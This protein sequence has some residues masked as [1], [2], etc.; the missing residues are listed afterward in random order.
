MKKLVIIQNSI[1]TTC[2]FRA[3]YIRKFLEQEGKVVIIAPNDCPTSYDKLIAMGCDIPNILT[4]TNLVRKI[5]AVLVMNFHI[6]QQRF[7]GENKLFVCHFLVT[8]LS[9][10]FSLIPFNK[11]VFL[12]IEGLGSLYK[13]NSLLSRLIIKMINRKNVVRI[14]CNSN[15]RELVGQPD[16]WVAGGIG[17]DI[18][19]FLPQAKRVEESPS[20]FTLLYVGRL[21]GDK[22]A[23]DAI[24]V[25]KTLCQHR[26]DV[27]LVMVG[28]IY[29]NNPSSF[30]NDDIS[31]LKKEFG[32]RLTFAGYVND[33]RAWYD[34]A[35]VL[36]L[37]SRREGFPVCVMEASAMGVPSI[38]FKVPGCEDAI[39]DNENG[40]LAPFGDIQAMAALTEHALVPDNLV[41]LRRSSR[42]YACHHFSD[43][44]K[45]SAFL[46]YILNCGVNAKNKQQ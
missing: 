16:D 42:E 33:P 2:L 44:D 3:N 21:I 39:Q 27:N 38:C 36:L 25:F 10:F 7:S 46:A 12:S 43:K 18:D 31:K 45:S 23:Y 9:T 35:D 22:G 6:L 24:S 29:P 28:D 32:E 15:E 20:S 26:D 14:F 17:V 11:Q 37:P 5:V 34:K 13:E 40:Y 8:Y 4:P 30:S 41:K 1:K 19:S